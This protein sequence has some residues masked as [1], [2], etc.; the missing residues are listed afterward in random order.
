MLPTHKFVFEFSE[1]DGKIFLQSLIGCIDRLKEKQSISLSDNLE[2]EQLLKINEV[3]AIFR[4]SRTTIFSWKREGWLPYHRIS[5]RIYFKKSEIIA[6][7][8]KAKIK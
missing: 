7:L 1:E 4:V 2:E 5:R 6:A 8:K 3:C